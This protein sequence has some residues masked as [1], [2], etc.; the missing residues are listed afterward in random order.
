MSRLL[1][2]AESSAGFSG[3][4]SDVAFGQPVRIRRLE[5]LDQL[6]RSYRRVALDPAEAAQVLLKHRVVRSAVEGPSGGN[7]AGEHQDRLAKHVF[8]V[9]DRIKEA[10]A[11]C[12]IRM[13]DQCLQER[14]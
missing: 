12:P 7:S 2:A 3:S 5:G 6:P 14:N 1:G 10:V 11:D 8:E 13:P 4:G 9:I